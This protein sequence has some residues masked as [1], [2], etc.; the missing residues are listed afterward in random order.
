MEPS[1]ESKPASTEL[2]AQALENFERGNYKAAIAQL[3]QAKLQT[4]VA[5]LTGGNI[6]IWLANAYEAVGRNSE[7][8]AICKS[9]SRHPDRDLRKNATYML[10]IFS[11]PTLRASEDS[12]SVIP[13][14]SS[15]LSNSSGFTGGKLAKPSKVEPDALIKPPVS[16]TKHQSVDRIFFGL[17][18]AI[19]LGILA[20]YALY[21]L[22]GE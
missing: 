13:A 4:A 1:P 19:A 18:L 3:E 5:T 9:L 14:F 17:L 20:I 12:Y 7:A 6:Q 16:S 2:Y 10:E 11:A 22:V 15:N 21:P 8:I